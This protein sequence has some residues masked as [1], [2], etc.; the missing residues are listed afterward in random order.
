MVKNKITR[1]KPKHALLVRASPELSDWLAD[2]S[3]RLCVSQN[4]LVIGAVEQLRRVLGW[5]DQIDADKSAHGSAMIDTL[6]PAWVEKLLA[7]GVENDRLRVAW[8]VW[9]RE[10]DQRTRGGGR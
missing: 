2:T 7:L 9:M 5:M 6:G 4:A 3:A 1:S 8:E 10:Q